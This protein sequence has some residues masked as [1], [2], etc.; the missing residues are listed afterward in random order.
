MS[1]TIVPALE[2]WKSLQLNY[3]VTV[4]EFMTRLFLVED[5][6][7]NAATLK[8][9]KTNRWLA[10]SLPLMGSW[11]CCICKWLRSWPSVRL[12]EI[13]RFEFATLEN[14]TELGPIVALFGYAIGNL[15]SLSAIIEINL[16][17][18]FSLLPA[19]TGRREPWEGGCYWDM[20][21]II[22]WLIHQSHRSCLENEF[23]Q[24]NIMFSGVKS[25]FEVN[26]HTR[27]V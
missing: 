20:R 14:R 13:E 12:W 27:R 2:L 1:K 22:V 23:I 21:K 4:Q 8:K 10:D 19:G 25:F 26:E 3:D 17:P 24:Q 15:S 11:K 16:V 9:T 5:I 6:S 7:F 18:R